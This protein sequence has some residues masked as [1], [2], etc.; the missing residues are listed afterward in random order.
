MV[1]Y[2]WWLLFFSFILR[3]LFIYKRLYIFQLVI[4]HTFDQ[5]R[6]ALKTFV[7]F[8]VLR[9]PFAENVASSLLKIKTRTNERINQNKMELA[10]VLRREPNRVVTDQP[11]GE[12]T[13]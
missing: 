12:L 9:R 4:C 13:G 6:R 8:I 7:V 5:W 11:G 1:C 3:L 2:T 10:P